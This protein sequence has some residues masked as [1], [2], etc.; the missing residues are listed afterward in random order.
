MNQST[1]VYD[2]K[3]WTKH[4]GD[5]IPAQLPAPQHAN[6][7]ALV[8]AAEARFAQHKAFTTCMPNGMH[9]TLT[10]A[11]VAQYADAFAVYLRE[12]IGLAPGTRVAVQTPNRSEER[13]VGKEC[14]P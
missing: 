6:L 1:S 12:C 13:R 14:V 3:P 5:A 7:A 4:Y 8:R 10:Y 11:Q 9:G 2:S